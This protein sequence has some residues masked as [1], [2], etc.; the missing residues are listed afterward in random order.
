M[1]G[2]FQ[3]RSTPECYKTG[4]VA[5]VPVEVEAGDP[6]A[7]LDRCNAQKRCNRGLSRSALEPA[8][9][10]TCMEPPLRSV[11]EPALRAGSPVTGASIRVPDEPGRGKSSSDKPFRVLALAP[12][13]P[14]YGRVIHAGTP[15]RRF[16][17]MATIALVDDD[18]NIVE[19]LK[20]FFEPKGYQVAPITMAQAALPAFG[21]RRRT[22]PS[23]T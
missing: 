16:Q 20:V 13:H 9:V 2:A 22:S 21:E 10:T 23:S 4:Q 14:D 3:A 1:V 12:A 17:V 18:E 6:Q 11:I 8:D 15:G 5:R 19:S 7:I